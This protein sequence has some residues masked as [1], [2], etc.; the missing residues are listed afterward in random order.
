MI[1][2]L[3][4]PDSIAGVAVQIFQLVE[5]RIDAGWSA[6]L[7]VLA[8]LPPIL[9]LLLVRYREPLAMRLFPE[10]EGQSDN[11]GLS[12]SEIQQSV[13][14]GLGVYFVVYPV[15]YLLSATIEAQRSATSIFQNPFV[16]SYFTEILAGLW[17]ILGS[18]GLIGAVVQ[19]QNAG[20]NRADHED[21]SPP[22]AA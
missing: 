4:T 8:L 21:V 9:G 2:A 15:A 5:G 13:L 22:G 6:L 18:R 17:L 19:F 20:R 12:A 1:V 16:Y 10:Q 3:K 14:L 11:R 7:S